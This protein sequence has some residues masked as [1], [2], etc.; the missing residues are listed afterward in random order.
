MHAYLQSIGT[1]W[2]IHEAR[3]AANTKAW[4]S[5]NEKAMGTIILCCTAS[6]KIQVAEKTTVKQIWDLLKESYDQLFVGSAHTEL[7][8][9]L[10][11]TR[12]LV[13][14]W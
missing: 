1:W 2:T 12:V 10:S 7:K 6:I 13:H 8:K 14:V 11:I 9:L 5:N 3:P 4:D